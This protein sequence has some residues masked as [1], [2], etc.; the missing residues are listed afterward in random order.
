MPLLR[1]WSMMLYGK[2][3][4]R[5]HLQTE[6]RT[7]RLHLKFSVPN[8]PL[9]DEAWFSLRRLGGEVYLSSLPKV[10]GILLAYVN[11]V[12]ASR[13]QIKLGFQWQEDR[14]SGSIIIIGA[15]EKARKTILS[16][17]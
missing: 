12:K 1:I 14:V 4:A 17:E 9:W 10:N 13:R 5:Q 6:Q 11:I 15:L 3:L 2:R 7:K 8:D 16:S